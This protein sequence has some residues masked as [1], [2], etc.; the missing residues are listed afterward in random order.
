M[1]INLLIYQIFLFCFHIDIAPHFLL[2]VNPSMISQSLV[3][4]VAMWFLNK[5]IVKKAVMEGSDSVVL[6]KDF[7]GRDFYSVF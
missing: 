2:K 3:V 5:A 4:V 1:L 7:V 6:F